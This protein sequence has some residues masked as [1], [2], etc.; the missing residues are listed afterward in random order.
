MLLSFSII[1]LSGLFL[2]WLFSRLRLPS[3]TGMIIAGMIIGPY[4]LSLIDPS[5]LEIS[6]ILRQI[7]LV[8]ILTRAGLSLN[9]SDLKN[10]GRAAIFLCFLPATCEIIGVLIFAPLLFKISYIEAAVAGSVLAAVSPAVVVPR[11]IKLIESGY[12][13]EHKIPQTILAGASADDV[14]VIVL[15]TSFSAIAAGGQAEV[16]DFVQIPTSIILGALIGFSCGVALT[17]FFGRF[18][19]RDS[20]KVIIT[21]SISFLLLALDEISKSSVRISG[22]IGI[23]ALGI[24]ILWKYPELARRLSDKYNRLWVAAEIILFVLV[25]A[26]VSL[27]GVAEYGL[28]AVILVFAAMIFRM[29][30]VFISLLKTPLTAKERLFC[31]LAYTPKATVQAA[32]GAIPLSMGLP[33]GRLVLTAAVM[34]ILITAPLGAFSIDS[35]YK[36]LLST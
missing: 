13:S 12:G 2:G 3:L 22:L 36:R 5:I 7:A 23:M 25:G 33:C 29:A 32:I 34:S 6:G 20:V 11:M 4:A 1:M 10:A 19:M 8:I 18:H 14:Y 21:L 17:I 27:D 31:M 9:L 24:S 15:F 28:R 16:L 26:A 30:G 35:S